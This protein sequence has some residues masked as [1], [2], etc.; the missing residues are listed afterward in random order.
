M[1]IFALP[2][3]ESAVMGFPIALD[4]AE[5]AQASFA[6]KVPLFREVQDFLFECATNVAS[7]SIV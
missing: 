6:R 1:P 7:H 5:C 2:V 4:V 3:A